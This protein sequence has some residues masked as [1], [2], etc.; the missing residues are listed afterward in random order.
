MFYT[1]FCVG[2]CHARVFARFAH[3][4][5][6]VDATL[7]FSLGRCFHRGAENFKMTL[8]LF[9]SIF[10]LQNDQFEPFRANSAIAGFAEGQRVQKHCIF[11]LPQS[12]SIAVAS[13]RP[14]RSR[15]RTISG[16][17]GHRARVFARVRVGMNATLA[18]SVGFAPACRCAPAVN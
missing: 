10:L 17:T 15:F 5:V 3:A 2:R 13:R 8:L 16:R 11:I 1:V 12:H 18:F 14:P 4:Q 9:F 7:A 6:G